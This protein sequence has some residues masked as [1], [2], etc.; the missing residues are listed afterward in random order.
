MFFFALIWTNPD[1]P[2]NAFSNINSQKLFKTR[3]TIS[4]YLNT[5]M[6]FNIYNFWVILTCIWCFG[7]IMKYQKDSSYDNVAWFTLG[8]SIF[9]YLN[10]FIT[11]RNV[12]WPPTNLKFNYRISGQLGLILGYYCTFKTREGNCMPQS[13]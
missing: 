11:I 13:S 5:Q 6:Y 1:M 4:D 9:N 12:Q 7:E 10:L 8:W 3:N 2:K